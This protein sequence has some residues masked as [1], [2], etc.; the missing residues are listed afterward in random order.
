MPILNKLAT[1]SRLLLRPDFYH[2]MARR[3]GGGRGTLDNLTHAKAAVDWLLRANAVCRGKGFSKVHSLRDGW[4]G[5]YVETTG[6]IIPTLYDFSRV[7]DYRRD[8]IASA[9]STSLEFLLQSQ[10]PDGAFGDSDSGDPL[11]YITTTP[12]VFDTGQVMF[13]LLAGHAMGG[14]GRCLESARRAGDWL[15]KVQAEDG[16]WGQ[17]TFSGKARTYYS[18]V[19]HALAELWKVTGDARYRDGALRQLR[20]VVAQQSPNGSFR[21]CSFGEDDLTVLHVIA[22][23]LDGLWKAGGLLGERDFQDAVR[24]GASALAKIQEQ[25]GVIAGHYDPEWHATDAAHCLTGLAQM[26]E[27]WL[28]VYQA[29]RDPALLRAADETLGFLRQKQIMLTSRKNIY[30]GLT[31]SYPWNGRYFPW[32]IPNWPQKFFI[33]ALLL[34]DRIRAAEA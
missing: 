14:D 23:T 7:T 15:L 11:T 33:D 16:S 13:G 28:L 12:L 17:F 20:W 19:A 1:F 29:D 9:I 6:Y 27:V 4:Y 25:K 2:L 32:A 30:G 34:R 26:A 31:G 3:T 24:R 10:Y 8:E 22:Y 5:P 21:N 18:R